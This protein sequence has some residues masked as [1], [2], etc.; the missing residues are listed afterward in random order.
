M[1]YFTLV[2]T[3]LYVKSSERTP[4]LQKC[5]GFRRGAALRSWRVH[6]ITL[7]PEQA[8]DIPRLI[9][10]W[11]ADGLVL[12]C[13]GFAAIPSRKVLGS[14]PTVFFSLPTTRGEHAFAVGEDAKET[15]DAAA[16]ELLQLGYAHYAF[17]HYPTTR[18]WSCARAEAFKEAIRL[19]GGTCAEFQSDD[20][21]TP[22][23]WAQRLR[24]WIR[25]LPRPCGIFAATDILGA[26][27]ISAVRRLGARIPEDFAV[28]GADNDP[29]ICENT[30]P[31][32]SSLALDFAS[33][34]RLAVDA[35]IDRAPGPRLFGIREIVRRASTFLPNRNRPGV[36]AALDLIRQKACDGLRAR[37]VAAAMGVSRRLAEI[38]F[39]SV[40]GQ[41]LLD[42]IRARRIAQAKELAADG[43]TP[44]E[45]IPFLCGWNGT[46][47]FRRAFKAQTG[48]T[49]RAYR[50]EAAAGL[51]L[52][53]GRRARRGS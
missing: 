42:A 35:V 29:T 43:E 46:A 3:I 31:T 41:T 44:L 8:P 1:L 19:N 22:L 5:D 4:S 26:R 45:T 15:A 13:G 12:D 48:L 37:D 20:K 25:E 52:R 6:V 14:L 51:T 11:K 40:T 24:Q 16:R 7:P 10:F 17:V 30:A 34:G 38:R 18:D 50:A 39:K 2:K 9:A 36:A 53:A 21:A 32:L 49:P 27:V 33:A 23:A 28:L 47:T